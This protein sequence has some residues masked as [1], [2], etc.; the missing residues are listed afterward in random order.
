MTVSIIEALDDPA[1]FKT[2]FRGDTWQ[3]WQ[4]FLQALFALPMDEDALAL[5]QHDTG[6]SEPPMAAFKESA[7]IIGRRGGKS[8]CLAL[9]AV[10]LATFRS[11]EQFLAPG[12]VATIAVIAADRKQGSRSS[13]LRLGC[14]RPSR[15]W[16]ASSRR[17]ETTSML[18]VMSPASGMG[19]AAWDV[20]TAS[21]QTAA[22]RVGTA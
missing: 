4:A 18:I 10:F 20:V 16:R 21:R 6:R 22:D 8:R 12:E 7:L 2:H 5:Y 1:L 17:C 11:Y 19:S 9:T 14:W 3:P 15:C 13:G